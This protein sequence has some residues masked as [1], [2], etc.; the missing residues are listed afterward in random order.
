MSNSKREEI[1]VRVATEEID[2]LMEK[3]STFSKDEIVLL[4]MFCAFNSVKPIIS[5]L[6]PDCDPDTVA[7]NIGYTV[8]SMAEEFCNSYT[9]EGI[10]KSCQDVE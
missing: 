7:M 9:L 5:S 6:G 10:A 4:S 1:C 3:L 2:S 8:M